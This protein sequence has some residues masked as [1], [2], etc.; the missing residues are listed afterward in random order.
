MA[1]DQ[2]SFVSV[3]ARD[4]VSVCTDQRPVIEHEGQGPSAC[5]T[6][7]KLEKCCAKVTPRCALPVFCTD[8]SG[9]SDVTACLKI[10][11]MQTTQALRV[12]S[13]PVAY[14]DMCVLLE[15]QTGILYKGDGVTTSERT[16]PQ[17]KCTPLT[18]G[19]LNQKP[20]R[21]PVK[22]RR[23]PSRPKRCNL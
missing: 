15:A 4:R 9:D 5:Q 7:P 14:P 8:P 3:Q 23:D 13:L 10:S 16:S 11:A 1:A 20:G 12:E 22:P 2:R 21:D 19:P 6:G 17:T 18:E